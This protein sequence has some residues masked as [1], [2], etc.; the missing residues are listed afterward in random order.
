ME[1]Q[2]GIKCKTIVKWT[3]CLS[4]R[5]QVSKKSDLLTKSCD[6]PFNSDRTVAES[7]LI[8]QLN[9]WNLNDKP[10]LT[11]KMWMVNSTYYTKLI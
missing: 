4:R 9:T 3:Q 10:L 5:G 8:G 2:T 7:A 1:V 11:T 6:D